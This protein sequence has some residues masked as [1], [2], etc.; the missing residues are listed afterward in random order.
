MSVRQLKVR[1]QHVESRKYTVLF[2]NI[3][4]MDAEAPTGESLAEVA[5]SPALPALWS[6][7]LCTGQFNHHKNQKNKSEYLYISLWLE[8]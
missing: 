8:T 7:L 2:V 3:N 5:F 4:I 6:S 1:P